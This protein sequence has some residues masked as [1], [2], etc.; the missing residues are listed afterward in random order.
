MA[1]ISD[2]VTFLKALDVDILAAEGLAA[3]ILRAAPISDAGERDVAFLMGDKRAEGML[4]QAR[5]ALIIANSSIAFDRETLRRNGVKAVVRTQFPRLDFARIVQRFFTA[6][7][8]TGIHPSAIIDPGAQIHPSVYIGPFTYVGKCFIDEGTVVYGHVH[9]YGNARIGRNVIIH[10]GA[11]IGAD[12]F[13]Y[14]QADDGTW[15]KFPHVGGVVI[16]D[17]V[18]IGANTCI[19]KGA[20]SDTI[21]RQGAKLDN[22]VH[23]AHNVDVGRNS[24]VIAHAVIA[25]STRIGENAW[26]A[27]GAALIE[28]ISVGDRAKVGIGAVVI[29]DIKAGQTVMGEPARTI[30]G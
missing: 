10:A 7:K 9:I 18:E 8:P 2:I 12:G 19:D 16:E 28:K 3:Q 4:A 20:L 25:G 23:I 26:I 1:T 13:G 21:I 6:P 5:G 17:N 24:M 27:P 29:R 22:L 11:V 15:T 14:A 30:K